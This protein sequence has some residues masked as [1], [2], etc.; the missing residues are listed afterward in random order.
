MNFL[1]AQIIADLTA[2]SAAIKGA[3][4][5]VVGYFLT[6]ESELDW[7]SNDDNTILSVVCETPYQ[8]DLPASNAT[9][10]YNQLVTD[11]NYTK[12]LTNLIK[13]QVTEGDLIVAVSVNSLASELNNYITIP[14]LGSTSSIWIGRASSTQNSSYT[15]FTGAAAYRTFARGA[16]EQVRG[17]ITFAKGE[18]QAQAQGST[19]FAAAQA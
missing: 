15:P 14:V 10:L 8:Y 11:S 7:D 13:A 19:G 3:L 2:A 12:K 16:V 17:Y 5:E 6:I 1:K 4:C 18:V 9:I